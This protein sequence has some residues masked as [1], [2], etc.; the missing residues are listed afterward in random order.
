MKTY[1]YKDSVSVGELIRIEGQKGIFEVIAQ[2]TCKGCFFEKK[3]AGVVPIC[4]R[5]NINSDPSKQFHK[6]EFIKNSI[7]WWFEQLPE[8][9]QAESFD[10]VYFEFRGNTEKIKKRLYEEKTHI[11]R[12]ILGGFSWDRSVKGLKYWMDIHQ[13]LLRNPIPQTTE[14]IITKPTSELLIELI[15]ESTPE[16][17]QH[18][19][20]PSRAFKVTEPIQTGTQVSPTYKLVKPVESIEEL[21]T[22]F[23]GHKSVYN[24]R[25][26]KIQ[27]TAFMRGMGFSIIF[28]LCKDGKIWIVEPVEKSKEYQLRDKPKEEPEIEATGIYNAKDLVSIVVVFGYSILFL[29]LFFQTG[30]AI[31]KGEQFIYKLLGSVISLS[32]ALYGRRKLKL[33]I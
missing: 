8:P 25:Y 23:E 9:L 6:L 24:Q 15:P 29:V 7:G 11:S 32:I 13:S 10:A 12:S 20:R 2:T 5:Q 27:N 30:A 19:K 22:V 21:A 28:N 31:L 1:K 17:K 26:G 33:N 18:R 4:Y 14:P 16:P 3:C